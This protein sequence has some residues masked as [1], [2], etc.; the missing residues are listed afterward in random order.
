MIDYWLCRMFYDLHRDPALATRFA[1]DRTV[2]M[3]RYGVA[4]DVADAIRRD[5]VA[6]LA[7][8]TNPFL[9]RYYFIIAGLS[10]AAFIE[11]LQPERA[12]AHG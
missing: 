7:G 9:L 8:R 10:D 11:G 4:G 5:D 3:K 12:T 6:F 1:A 2:V